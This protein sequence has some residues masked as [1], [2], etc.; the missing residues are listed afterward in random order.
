MGASQVASE[1]SSLSSIHI[2]RAT[3]FSTPTFLY[4]VSFIKGLKEKYI[5]Q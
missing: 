2:L 5:F 3:L 1:L 4:T